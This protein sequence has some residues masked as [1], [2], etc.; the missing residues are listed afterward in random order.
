MFAISGENLTKRL[1]VM[2]LKTIFAQEI[3]WFAKEIY[4]EISKT[5]I[6]SLYFKVR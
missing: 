3:G 1:R 6:L 5:R 2:T 4:F